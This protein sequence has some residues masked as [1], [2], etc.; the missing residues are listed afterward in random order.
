MKARERLVRSW[1]HAVAIAA[2]CALVAVAGCSADGNPFVPH[3][4]PGGC[5]QAAFATFELSCSPNDLIGV[6]ASGPCAMP[7]A[8]LSFYTGSVTE[9]SVLVESPTPGTCHVVLT[10]ATGFTYEADVVFTSHSIPSE[11]G[12]GQCPDYIGPTSGPFQVDNP[13]DTCVGVADD[14]ASGGDVGASTEAGAADP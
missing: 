9:W 10:F 14:A 8:S 5:I 13:S 2:S 7:D 6:T 1:P 11:P 3:A 12:C 4:C